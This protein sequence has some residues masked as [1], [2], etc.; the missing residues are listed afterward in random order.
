MSA[1]KRLSVALLMVGLMVGVPWVSM[2]PP[3]E[4]SRITS[5]FAQP[6]LPNPPSSSLNITDSGLLHIPYNETFLDGELEVTPI[7]SSVQDTPVQ[8]GIDSGN[9]WL[10][11]HSNMQGI[12]QGGQLTLAPQGSI[13]TISDFETLVETA[14]GW[15]G[16]G[17][18]Y[19]VWAVVQPGSLS[20]NSSTPLPTLAANGSS[21]MS[22]AAMGDLGPNMSGCIISPITPIPSYINNYSL[23]F[24]HWL[25]LDDGDAAWVDWRTSGHSWQIL[26]PLSGYSN[27]TNLSQTTP[28]A[29]AGSLPE[30]STSSLPLDSV[31]N[32]ASGD[33]QYRFCYATSSAPTARGGW[34]IDQA[35]LYNQGDQP[36]SW[37]H[38]N[39][40]GAYAP[41]AQGTLRL[42]VDLSGMTGTLELEIWANW[43]LQGGYSDN[44]MTLI[45]LNNGSTWQS[46]S[47]IPGLP[48]NGLVWQGTY[49]G[50]ESNG[51]VPRLYSL[52][53]NLSSHPNASQ[54][55][56]DFVVQTDGQTNYGGF[57]INGWE[58][59][60]IDDISMY[61]N[62]GT[63]TEQR[64]ML[65]NF[66][67]QPSGQVGDINGWNNA[68]PGV[69]DQWGWNNTT[70]LNG[71]TSSTESFEN[72]VST[73]S[74]WM[75]EGTGSS[76]WEIGETRNTSGY[77]PGTFHS[78]LQGAAINLTTRYADDMYTNLVTPTYE[79]PTNATARLTFRSWMCSEPNWDGGAVSISLD[80]GD[81]WWF[82]PPET[83]VFHDQISTANAN[84]PLYGEGIF[85]GSKVTGGC[86]ASTAPAPR[87]Y[88][89][90]T[91]E[92]NNFSGQ[93][94]RAR[95]TFFSDAYLEA[96][97]WYLDDA[98][99]EV[100]V[101]ETQGAW[102]SPPVSPTGFYGYGMLDA[103]YEQPNSTSIEFDVLDLN[104]QIIPGHE[105]VTLP[106]HLAL[107][108]VEY[109]SINL[110]IRMTTSDVFVTPSVHSL[111]LG[112]TMY[113]SPID[114]Q[115]NETLG[116]NTQRTSEGNL[117]FNSSFSTNL[118][119]FT[120]CSFDD[121]RI[122]S[123]GDN[124]TWTTPHFQPIGSWYSGAGNGVQVLNFTASNPAQLVRMTTLEGSGGELFE[125]AKI[126]VSCVQPPSYPSIEVGWNNGS[127]L[128]WPM[129]GTGPM[130]GYVDQLSAMEL[131][132]V[133]TMLN[134]SE[135][136]PSVALSNDS[137]HLSFGT[138]LASN[139]STS[140]WSTT[141]FNVHLNNLSASSRLSVNGQWQ[142]LPN[143]S[144]ALLIT[145]NEVCYDGTV[146]TSI[147][148]TQNLMQ[149]F[150]EL[151]LEGSGDMKI[152]NF[153]YL[154]PTQTLSLEPSAT[155]LNQAKMASF[156]GDMRATLSI[157]LHVSTQRGGLLL[158]MSA[159]TAPMMIESVDTPGHTRWLP[160]ET[161]SVTTHHQRINPHALVEDAPDI[162]SIE[163]A[164]SPTPFWDDSRVQVEVD[165]L[166][167]T[168]R[169]RQISGAG[170]ASLQPS[171][172]TVTCT[173]NDCT[174]T[175][176][177]TSTWL[178]D[179]VDD[180]HFLAQAT[181]E[182]SLQAGPAM[183]V[184][185][186][187]F[188]E[189]EN[190]LEVVGFEVTDEQDRRLDDW[191]NPVWP[192][193]IGEN[194]SMEAS[195]RVRF[196]GILQRWVG[197]GEAE[198]MVT[199]NAVPAKNTSGG[200]DE[201]PNEPVNWTRN[202][203][204]TVDADGMFSIPLS[205][206]GIDD[207]VPSN[208]WL[209]II[210]SISRRGPLGALI[211]TSEDKT[212]I[213]SSVRSL[214]DLAQPSVGPLMV[215][216][217]GVSVL[218]D[219]HT[220]MFGQDIAL[221][222][223]V[224]DSEGLAPSLELWYWLENRD[225]DNQNGIM[226][227]EEYVKQ[228]VTVNLGST[229]VQ[230]DLPLLTWTDIVSQNNNIG[231]ASVVV[232][233]ADLAGNSIS[234]GGEFGEEGDLATF[235]VQRRYD[236]IVDIE[237]IFLDSVGGHI[238]AGKN[239]HFSF[240][241]TDGNGYSSFD[242]V[243]FAMMG[244]GNESVCYIHHEPRFDTIFYDQSCF[245]GSPEVLVTQRPLTST[246][247]VTFSFI[248]D[249]NTSFGMAASEAV[250]SFNIFD[251]GQNIGLGLSRLP[252]HSWLP[253]NTIEMRWLEIQDGTAPVGEFNS[254]THWLHRNDVVH[255]E[256]GVYHQGTDILVN[257]LPEIGRMKW[258]LDD[259]KQYVSGN[260]TH[261]ATGIYNFSVIM[262]EDVMYYDHGTVKVTLEGY[263]N[264]HVNSLN[265]SVVMDDMAPYLTLAPGVL[266]TVSS[267]SLESVNV[268]LMVND[269]TD[270]GDGPLFARFMYY[271][272]G[273]PLTDEA[274]TVEVPLS[275]ALQSQFVYEGTLDFSFPQDLE[276][277]RSDTLLVWFEGFDRSGRTLVGLG[278][279]SQP[280][281]IGLTWV[282]F[283]PTFTDISA[284]P[285]R[286]LQGENVTIYVRLANEG[287]VS[288]NVV[289]NLRDDQGELLRS[290]E[291]S[292]NSSEWVNLIWEIEAW[293]S[294]RLGLSV[295]LENYTPMVPVPLADVKPYD[296]DSQSN[297]MALL[298]LSVLTLLITVSIFMVVRQKRL[299]RQDALEIEKIRR[300]VNRR[301][302]P[303]RPHELTESLQEE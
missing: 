115:S 12:G 241:I 292:L 118:A 98:G 209:E 217:S 272:M 191:S 100:D 109:P 146:V 258:H 281:N 140:S 78:G 158:D 212:V 17:S 31:L 125:R 91:Y 204:G 166:A 160:G 55:L 114:L 287:L 180:L 4:E 197:E 89:L 127:L 41:N 226:E 97:G 163:L 273:Q 198:V 274:G 302:P 46:V 48:G 54:A 275:T 65:A 19:D 199:I 80:E 28:T 174:V 186:T 179:D 47:P 123:F 181:D 195:G 72:P 299:E 6:Y 59:I 25:A 69:V 296:G 165:Q 263:G 9:G 176:S 291:L 102:I 88:D 21:V 237:S 233:G 79:V 220:L 251:E 175:W 66:T 285:Y 206:P 171:L 202:W 227:V 177:L 106:F 18:D 185:K 230:L 207:Q 58:G 169:F 167:T 162:V 294:G 269:D 45:S 218:A 228:S 221:Q 297:S 141:S 137:L 242:S 42:P 172:S 15:R 298:S 239:H 50:D 3:A 95:F 145:S 256:V 303:P 267:D 290:E 150:I 214:F 232:R 34:F 286:P 301:L 24:Q 283:E 203:T 190:D 20:T 44:M 245:I 196:E 138:V 187:I 82:I 112:T 61:S 188:N 270:M 222:L 128:N 260:I 108:P 39:L 74:G 130:L 110:R 264:Y 279:V 113:L 295:E 184:R 75:I 189:I 73:P 235:Q 126:E 154:S 170:Y 62:Y 282:A 249:W 103:W 147:S 30:W 201:W 284:T 194:I 159:N 200:P 244:Q 94:V 210:P 161:I 105:G 164:L 144:A 49:Y 57:S 243:Q 27:A 131:N 225:D 52:P 229:D 77:G 81:T 183:E 133:Q 71:A 192:F 215:I 259:G 289:V 116:P 121:F 56:L 205:S 240:S 257:F 32:Q 278:S 277:S 262:R 107:D 119:P 29:W 104:N 268:T 84:S 208:T 280:L 33:F 139:V 16:I 148:S 252:S 219:N 53:S 149:C 216:D 36:G 5:Q 1:L 248:F 7:W 85:D 173:M 83:S 156:E 111:S 211:P 182:E 152:M 90:K 60:F 92:F 129:Q 134:S 35:T 14:I 293:K 38:G 51:W 265:Y 151:E 37:F 120:A 250:P 234:G 157:P 271:R 40:T 122:T 87:G 99:I 213:V 178:L 136:S 142:N 13:T 124:L 67:T 101:F 155:F 132:G 23:S 236:A 300:I 68:V 8:Y 135:P 86:T 255:H 26:Q 64:R 254:T 288:G 168:P 253:S 70:G 231:R 93:S 224:S 247:D 96:D 193:H 11:G 153:K 261:S 117:V 2:V 10:G 76:L 22:T 63:A 238:L 266:E 43:D 223:S 246:F 276:I 143:G